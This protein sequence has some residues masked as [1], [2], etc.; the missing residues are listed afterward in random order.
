MNPEG[1]S[2]NE[3]EVS[4]LQRRLSESE[5]KNAELQTHVEELEKKIEE[6]E[7]VAYIDVLTGLKSRRAFEERLIIER[8]AAKRHED[9]LMAIVI[10]DLDGL[11]RINDSRELGHNFGD[12]ALKGVADILLKTARVTD[13]VCRIGGDEFAV[14]LSDPNEDSPRNFANRLIAKLAEISVEKIGNLCVSVG[15]AV[16]KGDVD[17]AKELADKRMYVAKAKKDNTVSHAVLE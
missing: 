12:L 17:G 11:K 15:G 16:L 9:R 13:E 4:D 7:A 1:A 3:Q 10:V 8:A 6:L 14:I 5:S 2:P